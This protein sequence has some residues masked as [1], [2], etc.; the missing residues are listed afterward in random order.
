MPDPHVRMM[1]CAKP[2]EPPCPAEFRNTG[3]WA[4]TR[5]QEAGW[6]FPRNEDKA[7]CPNHNPW[8]VAGWRARTKS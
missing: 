2:D 7:Y 8:W 1:P 3:R 5:A 4:Q 6:F